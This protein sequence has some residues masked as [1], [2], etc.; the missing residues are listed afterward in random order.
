[1]IRVQHKDFDVGAE[2]ADLRSGRTDSAR[3]QRS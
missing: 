3:S 2:I 1:M